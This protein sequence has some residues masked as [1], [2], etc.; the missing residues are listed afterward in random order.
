M[1][2]AM[3]PW[4]PE[5]LAPDARLVMPECGFEIVAG[6]VATIALPDPT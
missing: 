6:R 3:R 2:T 1:P 4:S 5:P